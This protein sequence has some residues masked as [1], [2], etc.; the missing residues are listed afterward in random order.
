MLKLSA[1]QKYCSNREC[2]TRALTEKFHFLIYIGT[3]SMSTLYMGMQVKKWY[4]IKNKK[5]EYM[6][7]YCKWDCI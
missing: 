7:A 6:H 5:K 3:V 1:V 4:H 2:C